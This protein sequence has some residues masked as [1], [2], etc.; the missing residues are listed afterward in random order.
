[1]P[2]LE[3]Q[4][5][6]IKSETST[7]RSIRLNL[8]GQKFPFKPGQYCL[9]QVPGTEEGDDRA[10][11]IASAPT[12]TNALVFATRQSQSSYKKA[13]FKL[14]PG[15][16][17]TVTGP[18]GRFV[19]DEGIPYTVFLSGGIG[20]TPLKSMIEYAVDRNLN[21]RLVL[22][23]GN[24]FPDEIPFRQQIDDLSSTSQNLKVVH[25]V[26]E[27]GVS[28]WTGETGRIN[29]SMIKKHVSD[30]DKAQYFIC[31]P[32]GMVA[33]LRSILEQMAVPKEQ[34]KIENFDGYE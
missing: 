6:G 20:I 21:N 16:M 5:Q 34:I 18:T 24:N 2:M 25:V 1:M 11:S 28:G 4:V 29:E 12:R 27:P 32:P 22:L 33:S 30:T 10:L 13:F 8:T 7:I 17:V 23:F 31:G 3:L 14:K 15:D 19:Y 9:I 26:S